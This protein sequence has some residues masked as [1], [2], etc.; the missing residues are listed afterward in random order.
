VLR[1][2]KLRAVL[3][4]VAAA[5][6]ACVLNPH[7]EDPSFNER[8]ASDTPKGA[9]GNF[10]GNGSGGAA[11]GGEVPGMEPPPPSATSYPVD[12]LAGDEMSDDADGSADA[13]AVPDPDAARR[14]DAGL[15]SGVA[16]AAPAE[17]P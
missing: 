3:W 12:P 7:G 14:E 16:D 2:W 6:H 15:A 1:A 10:D 8:A 4:A 13:G 9:P 11:S 5:A 17:A